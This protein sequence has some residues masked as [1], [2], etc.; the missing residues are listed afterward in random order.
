MVQLGLR[1]MRPPVPKGRERALLLFA[2]DNLAAI[3]WYERGS[4]PNSA[5]MKALAVDCRYQGKELGRHAMRFAFAQMVR[6]PWCDPE[7]PLYVWGRVHQENLASQAVCTS[8]G[9]VRLTRESQPP[10]E[11]WAVELPPLVD[12]VAPEPAPDT[13]PHPVSF[14]PSQRPGGV[15]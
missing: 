12:T 9:M 11:D 7:L 13:G 8:V 15:A 3:A 6:E 10:Y 5:F 14:T 4:E 1:D 2:G